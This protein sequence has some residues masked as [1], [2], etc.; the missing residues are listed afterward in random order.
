[1]TFW[2]DEYNDIIENILIKLRTFLPDVKYYKNRIEFWYDN[3]KYLVPPQF[4]RDAFPSYIDKY[5]RRMIVGW[6]I[7]ELSISPPIFSYE[8]KKKSFYP[9]LK[10]LSLFQLST[11]EILFTRNHFD[12]W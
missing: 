11:M 10:S 3:G 9:S 6:K 8:L 4:V 1:M 5:T 2:Y 7:A 12:I